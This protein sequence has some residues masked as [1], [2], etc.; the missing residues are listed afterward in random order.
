LNF[1]GINYRADIWL[2]GHMLANSTQVVGTFR[3]FDFDLTGKLYDGINS[4]AL[5][6]QRPSKNNDMPYKNPNTDLAFTFVD[7]APNPPDG[8][9]G[10]WR[11]VT[12]T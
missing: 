11:E 6:I 3:L 12:L 1:K 10:I 7:W 5:R 8:N 2:N 9:A 4:L